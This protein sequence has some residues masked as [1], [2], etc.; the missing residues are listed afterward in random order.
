MNDS[1]VGQKK[2][3]HNKYGHAAGGVVMHH[4]LNN[5]DGL[6]PGGRHL[7]GKTPLEE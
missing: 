7:K 1:G 2:G 4:P 3:H 6:V 5:G